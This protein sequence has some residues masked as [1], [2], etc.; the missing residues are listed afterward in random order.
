M[1]WEAIKKKPQK[2]SWCTQHE[3][4]SS[5]VCWRKAAGHRVR[6]L[7]VH[8]TEFKDRKNYRADRNQ[9]PWPKASQAQWLRIRLPMQG[10]RFETW[11][12]KIPHAAEQLSPWATT[13]EPACHS[14]YWSSHAW[15]PCSATREATAMRSR[16]LA[17][18]S[19][20]RSPQLE[21]ACAQQQRP[22]AAKNK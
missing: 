3:G 5:K 14:Y 13:T 8:Y 12:G 1:E 16:A 6:A 15:S 9:E 11:S 4:W 17:T 21:K 18:K 10:T 20:P 22:N 19:S 2:P 7:W